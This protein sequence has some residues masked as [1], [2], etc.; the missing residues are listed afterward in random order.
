MKIIKYFLVIEL[1]ALLLASCGGKDKKGDN[2]KGD[3]TQKVKPQ[4]ENTDPVTQLEGAWEIKRAEGNMRSMNVGTIY[5]F[6]RNTLTM[7]KG[8]LRNPGKTEVTDSTFSFQAE[9]N[10]YKF[11]YDYHFNGDTMVVTMQKGSGQVFHM[12]KK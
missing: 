3:T 11:M 2:K 10:E 4:A 9:G 1:S 6:K 5:E 12:V 8:G 7:S